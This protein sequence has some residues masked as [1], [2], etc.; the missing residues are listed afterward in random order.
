VS[1][2]LLTWT[3]AHSVRSSRKD[4]QVHHQVPA[5]RVLLPG[6]VV[7]RTGGS[8]YGF[9][10]QGNEFEPALM[11]YRHM[12]QGQCEGAV[13]PCAMSNVKAAK[14]LG[15]EQDKDFQRL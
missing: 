4:W 8:R 11:S 2:G 13:G 3:K 6:P 15:W 5:R 10:M 14:R 1:K 7:F 12:C 9:T